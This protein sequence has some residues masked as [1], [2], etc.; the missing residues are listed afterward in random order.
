MNYKLEEVFKKSGVPTHTFVK[1]PEYNKILVSL[2][3]KGRCLIVEGPSGIGKTTCVEKVIEVLGMKGMACMLSARRSEDLEIINHLTEWTGNG[4][5]IIDDFHILPKRSKASIASYM[6]ILADEERESDKLI[7]LGINK[8]G[9]SLVNLSADLN[10]RIDTVKLEKNPDR[11]VEHLINLGETVLN[12]KIAAK[13]EIIELSKGSFHIAQFLCN[14]LCTQEDVLQGLDTPKRLNTSMEIL[15]GKVMEEFAR[16]FYNK[17]R[18]FAVGSRLRREGRAPYLHLLYWL[19]KS[20]D[21]TIQVDDIVRLYPGHKISINQIVD[22]DFLSRLIENNPE[23]QDVIHYDN[24]SRIL[25]IE[26]PKFMFYLRNLQWTKFARQVGF[27]NIR[28][29]YEY[30]FALSFAGENRDLAEAIATTLM[31]RDIAVFYDRH[32]QHKILA[33][34]V[35]DYLASIYEKEARFVIPLLSKF[36]SKK[37]W[38]KFESENFRQRFGDNV[39]IPI[40]Y[41]DCDHGIFDESMKYGGITFDVNS[42]IQQNAKTICDCLKKRLQEERHHELEQEKK[43]KKQPIEKKTKPLTKKNPGT[44]KKKT[45]VPKAKKRQAPK[46]PT[47]RSGLLFE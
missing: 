3:T 38:T 34:N 37:I 42:S 35:E 16:I 26:D 32:E 21:W 17:A 14:E 45:A 1:P 43:A 2:R 30:D 11:L 15:L 19:S 20:D 22:K 24:N 10:N 39:I 25:T 44:K 4:I 40:W 46:V 5:V 31:E 18:C 41:S 36:F 7:L 29:K 8:A 12:V 47:V 28:F 27:I 6:K 9:D 33:T 13:K 23:I